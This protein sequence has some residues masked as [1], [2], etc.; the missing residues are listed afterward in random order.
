MK[1]LFC[2]KHKTEPS[3]LLNAAQLRQLNTFDNIS[4]D[5]FNTDYQ[6]YDIVLF[7]G[8]D[9][10]IEKVKEISPNI[11]VG[12]IDP[13]PPS[14]NQPIG[15]DF[16]IANGL[17]MKD[18]YLKYTPNIF[19]SYIYPILKK[20]NKD[21]TNKDKIVIG[22]HGNKI[23]L[24]SMHP[25]ITSAL[26]KLAKDFTIEFLMMYNIEKLGKLKTWNPNYEKY[27]SKVDI[28]IVPNLIPHKEL[29]NIES[30]IFRLLPSKKNICRYNEHVSDYKLR[31][32]A[33]SNPGRIFVFAQ[34]GIPVISDIFPSALQ[35]ISDGQN[36]FICYSTE[37]WYY[38][39]KK[40][41]VSPSLRNQLSSSMQ[42]NF[43][44]NYSIDIQNKKFIDFI[45]EL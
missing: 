23:H 35:M 8:Y 31:F 18:W 7:M 24:R 19:I 26:E 36:G 6:N 42:K 33:T 40:L 17:E 34:Y 43:Y 41:V 25:R 45:N 5:F 15:A 29:A 27:I 10:E 1:L 21:H 13:R 20:Q 2:T 39:L 11:K 16:I 9:H 32:K 4:I 30:N 38:A 3:T 44:N 37:A 28:G 14:S 12:I 22:Y